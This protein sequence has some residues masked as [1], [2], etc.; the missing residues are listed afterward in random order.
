ML[1]INTKV[2]Y[3]DKIWYLKIMLIQS[4]MGIIRVGTIVI[5]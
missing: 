1:D 2:Y 5:E 4:L 3:I